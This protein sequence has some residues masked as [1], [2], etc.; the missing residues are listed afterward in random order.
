[1]CTLFSIKLPPWR[2]IPESDLLPIDRVYQPVSRKGSEALLESEVLFC[3]NKSGRN[4]PMNDKLKEVSLTEMLDAREARAFAQKQLLNRYGKPLICLTLNI[5]GPVKVLPGVPQAFE[6]ACKRIE[7]IL[8]V[9]QTPVLYNI[10]IREKTGYEAIYCVDDSPEAVKGWDV[11]L[12]LMFCVQTE[13]RYPERSW[14]MRPVP[15]CCAANRPMY[16]A[17]AEDTL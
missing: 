13:R 4:H 6:E 12:T 14:A 16:A 3:S 7:A 1:M 10:S 11:C 17:A 8:K 9:Y 2:G 15:A 5:P